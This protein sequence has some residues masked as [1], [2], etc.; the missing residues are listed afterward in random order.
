MK[1]TRNI[2]V[3][4]MFGVFFI[5]CREEIVS[6]ENIAGNINE[7]VTF[8]SPTSY[9]F[10]VNAE[11]IS[12]DVI[13]NTPFFALRSSCYITIL[14]YNSGNVEITITGRSNE[15]IFRQVYTADTPSFPLV[16]EG[17]TPQYVQLRFSNFTGKLRFE[18]NKLQ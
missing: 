1:Q 3:L 6:P 4:L 8:Q 12:I 17:V 9:S 2:I 11:G 5:S 15:S 18:L 14:G 13:D 10:V 16:F 7:P